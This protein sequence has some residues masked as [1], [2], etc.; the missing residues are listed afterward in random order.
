MFFQCARAIKRS[1]LWDPAAQVERS[2]LPSTGSVLAGLSQGFDGE[3]YDAILQERQK[4]T[5][6]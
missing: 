1:G 2:S 3:G 5:L 4:A 6:Y